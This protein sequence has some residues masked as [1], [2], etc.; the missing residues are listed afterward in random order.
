MVHLDP[1]WTSEQLAHA[2]CDA[3]VQK[4]QLK[5]KPAF[6]RTDREAKIAAIFESV[7]LDGAKMD[8]FDNPGPLEML[9]RKGTN[10]EAW[11]QQVQDALISMLP[12]DAA[13]AAKKMD[14]DEDTK[15]ALA[16]AKEKS[17]QRREKLHEENENRREDRGDRDG[18]GEGKGGGRQERG[19]IECFNCG[20]FGHT[21]RDCPEP[22]K[23]KGKGKGKG[24]RVQECFNCGQTGHLSRDC[25]EPQKLLHKDRDLSG[26]N[27]G[28]RRGGGRDS[29]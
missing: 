26:Y 12:E 21:S 4:G 15:E 25:P 14:M 17:A 19:D 13:K 24:K 8:S 10:G 28:G 27:A 6:I 5:D 18:R 22:R 9:I 20:A 3:L 2:L 7:G 11:V 16:A 1:S 29:D 23:E